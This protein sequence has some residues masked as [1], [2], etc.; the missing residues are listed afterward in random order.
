MPANGRWDLIQRLKGWILN[1]QT[2][3][4]IIFRSVPSL[5]NYSTWRFSRRITQESTRISDFSSTR[6]LWSTLLPVPSAVRSFPYPFFYEILLVFTLPSSTCSLTLQIPAVASPFSC[7]HAAY[8]FTMTMGPA[9]SSKT[10]VFLYHVTL[11]HMPE[12]RNFT[13]LTCSAY[14]WEVLI[15]WSLYSQPGVL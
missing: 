15:D 3:F 5:D 11:R 4:L 9:D 7:P 14:Y 1:L 10:S 12:D 2:L 13:T 6:C 8:C